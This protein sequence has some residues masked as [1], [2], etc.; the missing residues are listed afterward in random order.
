MLLKPEAFKSN[1]PG[2]IRGKSANNLST[3]E[4][5]EVVSLKFFNTS[6]V[7]KLTYTITMD[8]TMDIRLGCLRH[9]YL[10]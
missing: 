2:Y 1:I 7:V 8:K 5:V 4:W 6:G 9:L 10:I 3:P